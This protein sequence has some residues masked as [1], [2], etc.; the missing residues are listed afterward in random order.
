[1]ELFDNHI[2]NTYNVLAAIDDRKQVIECC[3]QVLGIDVINVGNA[4]ERF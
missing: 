1:M 3:W 2:R 4:T